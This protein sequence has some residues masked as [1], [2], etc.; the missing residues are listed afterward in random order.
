[1]AQIIGPARIAP[2][3]AKGHISEK[4]APDETTPHIKA[5]IGANQV[6]GLNNSSTALGDGKL[7]RTKGAAVS[8]IGQ[9]YVGH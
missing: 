7:D 2:A 3:N 6:I 1:V 4:G 9:A 5:H 8:F